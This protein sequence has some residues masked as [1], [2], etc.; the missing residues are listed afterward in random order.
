LAHYNVKPLEI[1]LDSSWSLVACLLGL[2]VLVI[3]V[4]VSVPLPW[5]G[6][7]MLRLLMVSILLASASYHVAQAMGWLPG[8]VV[9]LKLATDGAL[10]IRRKRGDWVSVEVLGSSFVHPMLTIINL[11]L[12][13]RRFPVHVLLMPD[14]LDAESFRRLRVWLKWGAKALPE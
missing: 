12:E 1:A 2:H 6:S 3:G 5:A 11:K 4:A 14:V 7:W 13:A 10:S 9:A 8:S